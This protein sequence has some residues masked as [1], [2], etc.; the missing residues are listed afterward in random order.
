[1]KYHYEAICTAVYDGDTI[2]VDIDLGFGIWLRDQKLRLY[3]INAPEIRGE[4]RASGLRAK[5]WLLDQIFDETIEFNS[6]KDTKGK[7]GRWIAEITHID[8]VRL[9]TTLN[10]QMVIS[11]H[12][13][14]ANY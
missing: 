7:Y 1:V 10:Q 11:G 6:L 9:E 4:Q 14:E 12:A 2:T 5:D 13:I 8:G 3:G